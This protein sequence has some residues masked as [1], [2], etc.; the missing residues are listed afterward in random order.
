MIIVCCDLDSN[1]SITKK[2]LL[3]LRKNYS[4]INILLMGKGDI[5]TKKGKINKGSYGVRR[6]RKGGLTDEQKL[7]IEKA[8]KARARKAKKEKAVE[9]KAPAPKPKASTKKAPAKKKTTTK[10]ATTK[11]TTAKKTAA[12]ATERK[13]AAKKSED[14]K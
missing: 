7:A 11:K 4:L 1:A 2:I 6:M 8:K 13:P 5:K 9:E 10:T 3:I 12:K 14:K